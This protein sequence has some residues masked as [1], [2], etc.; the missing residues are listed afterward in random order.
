MYFK[1]EDSDIVLVK[2]T[3][4]I[5]IRPSNSKETT[6][7][8][9]EVMANSDQ[10]VKEGEEEVIKVDP[11]DIENNQIWNSKEYKQYY[12]KEII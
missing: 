3:A 11:R 4:L 9:Y 12:N 6:N 1:P 10:A 8:M 5:T 7:K 2:L